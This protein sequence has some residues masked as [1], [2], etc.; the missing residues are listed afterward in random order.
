MMIKFQFELVILYSKE[1]F[2]EGWVCVFLQPIFHGRHFELSWQ[3]KEENV[4][5]SG[6]VQFSVSVSHDRE[7]SLPDAETG[8]WNAVLLD[9]L[10]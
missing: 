9:E 6:S 2:G 7:Q 5:N 1:I 3:E 4:S 8:N 10:L